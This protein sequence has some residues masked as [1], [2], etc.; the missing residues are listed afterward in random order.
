[1]TKMLVRVFTIVSLL[2]VGVL[3]ENALSSRAGL[4]KMLSSSKRTTRAFSKP[5]SVTK[6]SMKS[7]KTVENPTC[8]QN[9]NCNESEWCK[10]PEMEAYCNVQDQDNP[11]H[12]PSP[13]C[14]RPEAVV[15]ECVWN[16]DCA[17]S[18]WCED[19]KMEQYCKDQD[20]HQEYCPTPMCK[21]SD[22]RRLSAKKTAAKK[23]V[24]KKSTKTVENPTCVQ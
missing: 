1:M 7:M 2:A 22:E 20:A 24:A 9:T 14:K 21:W 18:E 11:D 8:V 10:D 3:G 15:R 17:E 23:P 13:M 19:Q 12:C 6:K 5:T 16:T 4:K